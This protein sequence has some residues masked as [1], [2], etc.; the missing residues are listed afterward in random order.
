MSNIG[1][2]SEYAT[3]RWCTLACGKMSRHPV[4]AQA[5]SSLS[6]KKTL[7]VLSFLQVKIFP[8][9]PRSINPQCSNA[10][11]NSSIHRNGLGI[12]LCFHRM[13]GFHYNHPN[14]SKVENPVSGDASSTPK[15]HVFDAPPVIHKIPLI[16]MVKRDQSLF[17]HQYGLVSMFA[18]LN[19][20]HPSIT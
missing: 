4:F 20:H 17:V 1:S 6:W 9:K 3:R 14:I 7:P 8:V 19:L 2:W 16:S 11:L 5:W 12:R 10:L 13:I 18:H 15:T